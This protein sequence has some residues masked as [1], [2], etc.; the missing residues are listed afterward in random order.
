MTPLIA[1]APSSPVHVEIMRAP[2]PRLSTRTRSRHFCSGY[3]KDHSIKV[4][5]I[6]MPNGLS[7]LFGP[8]STQCA[9]AGMLA[10]SNLN[11]F[12][13]QLQRG[14]SVTLAG[15][16][17][18]FSGFGDS[19]FNLGLQCIQSYYKEFHC[20][21]VLDG[22]RAKCNEA[23]RSARISIK[24]NTAWSAIFSESAALPRVSRL[25]RRTLLPSSG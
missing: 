18:I 9:D 3:I 17:V 20:S 15:A 5:M 10:M 14:C 25:P 13:L 21:A 12:L 11:K 24:K 6:F 19:P 2:R 4:T 22:A 16:E 7:M 23:M 1:S 8:V